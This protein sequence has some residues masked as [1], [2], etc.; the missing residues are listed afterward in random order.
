MGSGAT[1]GISVAA[2]LL[3]ALPGIGPAAGADLAPAARVLIVVNN[4]SPVSKSIGEYYARRRGIPLTNVCTIQAPAT[5]EILRPDFDR[6]AAEVRDCLVHKG[7]A[8]NIY[9]IVTTLGVPLK[10]AGTSGFGGDAASVDSELTLLYSDIESHAPH[11]VEG[12]LPNPFFGRTNAS[13][14]HPQFPMYMVT[15][16]AAF[17]FAGVR[18]MIDRGLV[19]ANRGKFVIDLSAAEARAM[20]G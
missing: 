5:E 16:L 15:R 2:F 8:E 20:D 1:G 11:R 13:F 19:A 7:L 10:I 14:S 18:D 17:D 12:M 6:L 4:N 3:C 9:Y